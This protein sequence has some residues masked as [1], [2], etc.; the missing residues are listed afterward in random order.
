MQIIWQMSVSTCSTHF[1]YYSHVH[2]L[3]P[4]ITFYMLRNRNCSIHHIIIIIIQFHY[5]DIH[6]LHIIRL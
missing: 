2:N 3:Q 4:I 1:K 6:L 5:V